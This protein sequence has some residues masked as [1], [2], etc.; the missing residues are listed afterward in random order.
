MRVTL[1]EP[2]EALSGVVTGINPDNLNERYYFYT[3]RQTNK[4]FLKKCPKQ[5]KPPTPSQLAAR[6]RFKQYIQA[7]KQQAC[8]KKLPMT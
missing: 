1:N 2:F 7:R 3:R 6:E 5:T 8:I 4:V